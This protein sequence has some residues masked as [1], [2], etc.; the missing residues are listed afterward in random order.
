VDQ[1]H[2]EREDMG[3]SAQQIATK[4]FSREKILNKFLHSIHCESLHA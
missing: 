3:L 2:K 1:T 4:K